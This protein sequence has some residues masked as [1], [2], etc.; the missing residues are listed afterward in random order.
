MKILKARLINFQKHTDTP[1]NFS[2]DLNV[3]TG[4]SDSG[5]TALKR[6]IHWVLFNAPIAEK[7]YRRWGTKETTVTL[8][9]D[10][11]FEVERTRTDT[12]NRYI[13]RK[14]GCTDLI[15]DAVGKEIPEAVRKVIE[16]GLLEIDETKL[17]LNIAEQQGFPFLLDCPPSFRAKLFN[18]LTGNELLDKIF[19]FLN[20][21]KLRIQKDIKSKEELSISQESQRAE[22]EKEYTPLKEKQESASVL[23]AK[24]QEQDI[25]VEALKKVFKKQT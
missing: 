2:P 6:S 16:V 14:E 21:E 13:L 10:N 20:K 4:K 9:L 24:I 5:K 8:W 23:L 7:D 1:V 22:C 11:G 15:F 3:I 12:L 17:N 19:S 25:Y 18:K